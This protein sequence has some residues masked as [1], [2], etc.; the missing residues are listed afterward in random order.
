M[1]EIMTPPIV[2]EDHNGDPTYTFTSDHS[3]ADIARWI[4]SENWFDE[5]L[6]IMLEELIKQEEA[7]LNDPTRNL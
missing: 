5:L 2:G 3:I 1:S 7:K 4:I 6:D